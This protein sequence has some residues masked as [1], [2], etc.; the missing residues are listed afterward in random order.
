MRNARADEGAFLRKTD[1]ANQCING[2]KAVIN[3][4]DI[5]MLRLLLSL[6]PVAYFVI[7]AA[8]VGFGF[9]ADNE[10]R[11]S[12]AARAEA[13]EGEM[14]A[15]VNLG[16]FT[17]SDADLAN[18]VHVAA[19]I[20]YDHAY[21][22]FKDNENDSNSHT[23]LMLFDPSATDDVR[24]V[25]AAIVLP[26]RDDDELIAYLDGN[27]AGA[28]TMSPIYHIN[29]TRSSSTSYSDVARD[30]FSE[31]GF[32][33]APG[34]FYLRPFIEGRVAALSPKTSDSNSLKTPA[35]I[36]ALLVALFGGGKMMMRRR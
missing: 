34:F 14:P 18:E 4:K 23:L 35:W 36:A 32:T 21:T 25:K 30:A 12:I 27:V 3:N 20:N 8:L 9:Y 11:A 10:N 28:S 19:Q 22:L 1:I 13:L 33:R 5:S 16:E 7:A 26:S 24:T 29:G 17:P 6:P 2:H 15:V 31:H